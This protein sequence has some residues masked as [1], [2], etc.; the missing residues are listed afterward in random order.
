M[1][2]GCKL[3]V[4]V[5]TL[6]G[7]LAPQVMAQDNTQGI[8]PR[9][10]KYYSHAKE[11]LAQEDPAFLTAFQTLQKEISTIDS[12]DKQ[13]QLDAFMRFMPAIEEMTEITHYDAWYMDEGYRTLQLEVIFS[14]FCISLPTADKGHYISVFTIF[15]DAIFLDSDDSE[16]ARLLTV[17]EIMEKHQI[18]NE[19]AQRLLTVWDKLHRNW[20]W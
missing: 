7:F 18:S 4:G 10:L 15:T 8:A 3:L 13:A 17:D 2:K 9:Y 5:F 20:P 11:V 6:I 19:D 1:T 14:Y 12:T 16:S